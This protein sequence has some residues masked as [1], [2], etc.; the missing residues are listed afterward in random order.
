MGSDINLPSDS[1]SQ[2][3]WRSRYLG[4]RRHQW[5]KNDR[6]SRVRFF[7]RVAAVAFVLLLFGVWGLVSLGWLIA[8]RLLGSSGSSG[9]LWASLGTLLLAFLGAISFLRV[10]RR[11]GM[12]FRDV[13]DAA[14]RVADGDYG[15]RVIETG[16]PPVRGLAR[17]FNT[18]TERLGNHELARRNLM[19]DIAHELRTPLTIMRGKLEGLLDRVYPREDEQLNEIL[20]EANLLSRLIEDLRTLALS[21]TGA[22]TLEKEPT[23]MGELTREVISSFRDEALAHQ[24]GVSADARADLP[25]IVID[26]VRIR[27]VLN[28]LLSNALQHTPAGGSIETRVVVTDQGEMLVQ[29]HDT[30]SGMT[31]EELQRAFERFQ[32]GPQSRGSGLG[33]TIARNLVLAHGGEMRATSQPGSGTTISFTLPCDA[34]E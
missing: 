32:K 11:I 16:P 14:E 9:A 24:V 28:N 17:A 20:D 7:R 2:C 34:G 26:A 13:M 1:S 12:P 19:A 31:Q 8:S 25:P 33:L 3:E 4:P 5:S 6:G 29:V 23:D 21:E 10:V 15:V 18:M 27:Q 22:L 30:G